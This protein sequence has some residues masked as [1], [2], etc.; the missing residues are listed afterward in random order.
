M[1]YIVVDIEKTE[2]HKKLTTNHVS[3]LCFLIAIHFTWTFMQSEILKP[4]YFILQK[5]YN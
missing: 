3:N 4:L 1:I 5:H 2:Q